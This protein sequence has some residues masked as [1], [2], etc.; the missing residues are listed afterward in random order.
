MVAVDY[1]SQNNDNRL[2]QGIHVLR[3]LLDPEKWIAYSTWHR[4][5]PCAA[6]PGF[7]NIEGIVLVLIGCSWG[8]VVPVVCCGTRR[9]AEC[10]GLFLS[11]GRGELTGATCWQKQ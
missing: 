1:G 6:V 5:R 10:V 4:S 2:S 11:E 7:D 9:A 8:F 3:P